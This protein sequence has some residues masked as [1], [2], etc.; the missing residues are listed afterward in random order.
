MATTHDGIIRVGLNLLYLV[1]GAVG[2]TETYARHLIRAIARRSPRVRFVA[3]CGREAH[4]SL[5]AE[6]W[7]ANVRVVALPV[8]C[9]VKP[10]AS[11]PS[12]R[13]SPPLRRT[14]VSTSCT[15]SAR[16]RR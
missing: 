6:G 13:C 4:A 15:R 11:S 16:P 8:R 5:V 1:P 10:R 14:T 2:G 7:P 12:S 9:A 3:F